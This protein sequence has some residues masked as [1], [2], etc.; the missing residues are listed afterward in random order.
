M[1][2][3]IDGIK[4]TLPDGTTKNNAL[5]RQFDTNTI[6]LT[7]SYAIGTYLLIDLQYHPS[8]TNPIPLDGWYN[9]LGLNPAAPYSTNSMYPQ[10]WRPVTSN[11]GNILG[12]TWYS[13][14]SSLFQALIVRV[15]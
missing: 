15:A 1:T 12:G 7:T 8:Y 6:S 9:P 13:R 5:F 2:I 14:G 10:A 3:T 11:P 4:I